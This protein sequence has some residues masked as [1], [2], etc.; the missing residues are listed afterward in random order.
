MANFKF[1]SGK[2]KKEDG[3]Y[4][5]CYD[6]ENS[7]IFEVFA[8]TEEGA[9]R[10]DET[11]AIRRKIA[12][13]IGQTCTDYIDRDNIKAAQAWID[14]L[15]DHGG[16][17]VLAP[18]THKYLS[19]FYIFNVK[20]GEITSKF[21]HSPEEDNA[22]MWELV[23]MWMRGNDIYFTAH[24]L[25][26]EYSFI[27]YNTTLLPMLC[28]KCAKKTIIA[29][30]THDIKSIEFEF[31][32]LKT[33]KKGQ[34]VEDGSSFIIRDSYLMTGKSIKKLGESYKIPKL[35][36]DYEVTR[37]SSEELTERDY[38]YNERDNVIALRAILEIVAQNPDY[39]D[40]KKIPMSATQHSRNTCKNN[41]QVNLP[42]KA[43]EHGGATCLADQHSKLSSLFNMPTPELFQ[44]FFNASGGG[45][46]GVNPEETNKWH[47]NVYSFDIS[48]AHPSQAF[49]KRFPLGK[50]TVA[51][52]PKDFPAVV[53]ELRRKS[54][55]MQKHPRE[56]Y[57]CYLP[58]YDYLMKVELI[59]VHERNINGNIIN[60]LGAGKVIDGKR[61]SDTHN[62]TAMNVNGVTKYGKTRHSDRYVKWFYGIDLIYHLSF[63]DISEIKIVECYKYPLANCDEYMIKKLEFYGGAKEEYK[64][65]KK[66]AK[67]ND[68]Q[69]TNAEVQ[70][71]NLVEEYT[72]NA[73]NAENYADFL[74][75][76]L[77]RIKAI[78]NSAGFGQEY[79][80]P[81]HFNM[82]FTEGFEIMKVS[83]QNYAECIK[84]TSVH[85]CVGAYIAMWTRFELACMM[86]EVMNKGG[87]IFYFATDSIK[88]NGVPCDIFEGWC[89]GHT[90][91][92]YSRNVWNFGKVDCENADNPS[93]FYTPETLKHIDICKDEQHKDYV[94]S[95]RIAIE[96]TVSG[97]KAG[98]YLKDFLK[99]TTVQIEQ[100]G[101][102]VM[103]GTE[104]TLERVA[105]EGLEYTPENIERVQRELCDLFKPQIIPPEKTGK[106]VRDR[107]F[108]GLPTDLGQINFGA[109]QA[110][111][112]NLGGYNPEGSQIT[113]VD[114]AMGGDFEEVTN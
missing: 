113:D 93:Y 63:Y 34:W 70:A 65:L 106:L 76:E 58:S 98:I 19:N 12:E 85:Y 80:N 96:Y 95:D 90:S 50:K 14:K 97:F 9:V 23:Q 112:Y 5:V 104:Y 17:F 105:F 82:E 89:Y 92:H 37:I 101:I 7:V 57:N 74:S 69:T 33:T 87:N 111:G 2:K 20:S 114:T 24:N 84:K 54:L 62:R 109:L 52:D 26:Y 36:Y 4:I 79:Q 46:I 81:V 83:E 56:F 25:D 21:A 22:I 18:M 29:N 99:R 8:E 44:A 43:S 66:L 64:R 45:L 28:D 68:F 73:I 71:S 67:A 40:V 15:N 41:P 35:D 94:N 1:G 61:E 49:N 38:K 27:R 6:I 42:L 10:S 3:Q 103:D 47:S 55:M 107:K 75:D 77:L 86:W 30:G 108:A 72:K 110:I 60:S 53:A 51:V 11:K 88:A 78:F 31:G 59:G 91:K 16:K 102:F 32:K 13:R 100:C 39:H 48:S